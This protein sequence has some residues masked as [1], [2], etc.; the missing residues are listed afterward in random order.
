VI[1][2][3]K[4][5]DLHLHSTYSDGTHTPTELVCLASERKLSAISITDHDTIDAT[6]EALR[7]GLSFGVK[8]IPGVELSVSHG[9]FNYHLL[10]YNYD[11]YNKEFCAG[12]NRLQLARNERNQEIIQK[13]QKLGIDIS[14]TELQAVSLKGQTGRPHIARLLIEKKI[15]KSFD[16]AFKYYLRR[17]A[18]AYVSRYVFTI[19]EAIN[20]IHAA[21]GIAVLAHPAQ[22][23]YSIDILSR[24]LGELTGLGLD[25]I[26]V[27]YPSQNGSFRNKLSR[28]AGSYNLLE[29]GGSDYH[30]EIR[31]GTSL[32]GGKSVQ[33]PDSVIEKIEE[34]TKENNNKRRKEN[35]HEYD[36]HR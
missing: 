25:G 20:L 21:G 3:G 18:C 6:A 12:L 28:L 1:G 27:Y 10:A 4:M 34:L 17:G 5:I 16:L 15:V 8:V 26:E 32:A 23:T 22:I 19:E 2:K 14:A 31:A 24:L 36:S 7:A 33:V 11:R 35:D 30:G 9:E 13:L 29:T